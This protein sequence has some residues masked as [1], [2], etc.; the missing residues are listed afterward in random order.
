MYVAERQEFYGDEEALVYLTSRGYDCNEYINSLVEKWK[1]SERKAFE[2]CA[3]G[4]SIF[5]A[6]TGKS[7]IFGKMT[8]A[9]A[10]RIKQL[11]I[12]KLRNFWGFHD[13]QEFT[14][15]ATMLRAVEWCNIGGFN[16]WWERLAKNRY[17]DIVQGGV[18][19]VPGSIWLFS[20]CRSDFSIKIMRRALER[21]LEA[22]YIPEFQSEYP[23]SF[24]SEI[25]IDN[26]RGIQ[27]IDCI[28][29]ACSLVFADYKLFNFNPDSKEII[30]NAFN[31]ILRHQNSDGYWTWWENDKN[32][33]IEATA[34]AIHASCWKTSWMA[35]GC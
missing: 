16:D 33:D 12:F 10:S 8:I 21:T 24:N 1:V 19:P 29:F 23:W 26:K 15:D 14:I 11:S 6:D 30:S 31:M 2:Q 9:E 5:H 18:D 34:M 28:P 25:I 35:K 27:R 22:L 7:E 13:Q 17:E 32:S 3:A 4:S 20:N